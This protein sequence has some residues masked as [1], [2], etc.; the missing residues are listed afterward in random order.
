MPVKLVPAPLLNQVNEKGTL[1][2]RVAKFSGISL[3]LTEPVEDPDEI[4]VVVAKC[5]RIDGHLG[6]LAVK[7]KNQGRQLQRTLA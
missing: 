1:R 5:V 7:L 2:C 4:E 3:E 6:Q